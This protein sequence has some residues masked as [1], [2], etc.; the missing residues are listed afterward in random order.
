MCAIAPRLVDPSASK[1]AG[2]DYWSIWCKTYAA[3]VR[4]MAEAFI[5]EADKSVA[6]SFVTLKG[7]PRSP[8]PEGWGVLKRSGALV[9]IAQPYMPH[10][11][12]GVACNCNHC[13]SDRE[14]R[15]APRANRIGHCDDCNALSGDLIT[16]GDHHGGQKTVCRDRDACHR[17]SPG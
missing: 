4:E 7:A 8:L 16:K 12:V 13:L 5:A 2:G 17:R 14:A 10:D 6:S 11:F 9:R 15:R 3:L 1:A